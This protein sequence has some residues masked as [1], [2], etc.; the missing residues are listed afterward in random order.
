VSQFDSTPVRFKIPKYAMEHKLILIKLDSAADKEMPILGHCHGFCKSEIQKHLPWAVVSLMN[1]IRY[2]LGLQ[3]FGSLAPQRCLPFLVGRLMLLA[4]GFS[5]SVRVHLP[6][7]CLNKLTA[8][9]ASPR[10]NIR[11]YR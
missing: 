11:V 9:L 10:A 6:T 8:R 7:G 4:G 3:S 5:S 1:T 2:H